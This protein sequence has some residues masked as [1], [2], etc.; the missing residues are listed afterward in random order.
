LEIGFMWLYKNNYRRKS[1]SYFRYKPMDSLTNRPR[2]EGGEFHVRDRHVW[3]EIY[4]LDS[5]TD[6]REYLPGDAPLK[7]GASCEPMVLLDDP[8]R[9]LWSLARA[10]F[11]SSILLLLAPLLVMSHG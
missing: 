7:N 6:Y 5:S 1:E 11:G 8:D 3:S 9:S 10:L 2:A 4:Y